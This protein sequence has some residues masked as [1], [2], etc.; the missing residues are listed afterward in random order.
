[1]VWWFPL[2]E[3]VMMMMNSRMTSCRA[4]GNDENRWTKSSRVQWLCRTIWA[5]TM[6][7]GRKNLSV[8]FSVQ[9]MENPATLSVLSCASTGCLK[10]WW[11]TAYM[12]IFFSLNVF[13]MNSCC[14]KVFIFAHPFWFLVWKVKLFT[15]IS[16]GF[17][18]FLY[19]HRYDPP[20]TDHPAI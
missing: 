8:V 7:T 19:F 12:L 9:I 10:R 20:Y 16:V 14:F 6:K 13:S 18:L 11:N 3:T 2:M 5:W 15:F 17:F 1:M 4:C